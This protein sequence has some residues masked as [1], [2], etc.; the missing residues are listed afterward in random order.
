MDLIQFSIFYFIILFSIIGYGNLLSKLLK[1]KFDLSELGFAGLL[2]L[3]L[4]SY[5]SNFIFSHSYTHNSLIHFVGLLF[6]FDLFKK[7]DFS[8]RYIVNY[9]DFL[10]FIHWSFNA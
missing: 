2:I 6:F 3:I 5:I 8:K 7:R 10:C 1:I 9:F 4:I